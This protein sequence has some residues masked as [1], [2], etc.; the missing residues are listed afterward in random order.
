MRYG[1][2]GAVLVALVLAGCGESHDDKMARTCGSPEDAHQ[3]SKNAVR[4]HLK[5]PSTAEFPGSLM[6][7]GV[8]FKKV[9]DCTTKIYSYFDAQNTYG[10]VTRSVYSVEMHYNRDKESWGYADLSIN[11]R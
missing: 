10:A 5:S 4:D 3:E 9:D 1:I 8:D 7:K 2:A 11:Q 6:D